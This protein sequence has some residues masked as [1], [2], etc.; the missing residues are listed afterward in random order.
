MARPPDHD[1]DQDLDFLPP[2]AA[3]LL[4]VG[5]KKSYLAQKIILMFFVSFMVWAHFAELHEVTK[6]TGKIISSTHIQTINNL[7][8]GIVKEILVRDDQI[9]M[10]N[11][12]L[13]RLDPTIT[14]AKYAQDVENY[15]RFLAT[16]ERLR[17][18]IA[19]VDGFMPSQELMMNAPNLVPQEQERFRAHKEKKLND[20]NIAQKDL[21]IKQQEL[22]ETRAK[23]KDA[24]LQYDYVKEQVKIAK[25]LAEKKIYS[26]MDYIKLMRDKVEQEYQLQLL[27][28]N[29]KRQTE[30]LN[31]VKER[32]KQVQIRYHNDDLQELRDVEG[33]LAEARGAQIADKDRLTRTEI[34]SPITGT[35]RDIKIRTRGGVIQPGE[36]IMDIV[37]LNDTLIVEA[38]IAPADVGFLRPGMAATVKVTAYDFSSYGGLDAT[39]EQISPDTITDKREVSFYRVLLRTTSNILVK[40]GKPHSILPGMQVEVDILTGKKS[41]LDYFLKPFTR[42]LQNAMTER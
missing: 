35:I 12:V 2:R 1:Q 24:K 9:V 18:Q 39:I 30:A 17:A 22:M 8:G 40:D 19:N 13:V 38:Q 21:N 27:Q 11:Q 25:P 6:G 36:A 33:R 16:T 5:H 15:Y 32:L 37:P 42:A 34:R 26:R 31:Q 41:V 20:I 28:V 10:Q 3:A 14:E 4:R 7:E 29:L 23:L